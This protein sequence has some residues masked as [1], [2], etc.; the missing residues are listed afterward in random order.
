MSQASNRD[1]VFQV[2]VSS[3]PNKYQGNQSE[4][5]K[6]QIRY[7]VFQ[8]I[9]SRQRTINEILKWKQKIIKQ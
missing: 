1:K 8:V 7:Q 3:Q 5:L 9:V 2:R 6:I 4:C